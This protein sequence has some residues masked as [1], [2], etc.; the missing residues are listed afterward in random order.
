MGYKNTKKIIGS[1]SWSCYL[2]IFQASLVAKFYDRLRLIRR[3]LRVSNFFVLKLIEIVILWVNYTIPIGFSLFGHFLDIIFQLLNLLFCLRITDDG[4]VPEMSI[5]M[6]HMITESDLKWCI[7]LSRSL[8]LYISA[9][10]STFQA[11]WKDMLLLFWG[12]GGEGAATPLAHINL[13]FNLRF[14]RIFVIRSING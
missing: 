1:K 4:S 12:G 2:S 10:F 13:V 3:V 6:I 7:H 11:E 8:Y 14:R 9:I 5:I